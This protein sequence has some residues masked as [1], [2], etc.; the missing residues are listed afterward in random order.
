M[1]EQLLE[2]LTRLQSE[3]DDIPPVVPLDEYFKD[4]TVEDCI[5]CNQVGYGRPPLKDL[6]QHFRKIQ[7]KDEVQAVLVGLHFDW[8]DACDNTEDWPYA[9]N[10]HIYASV[11]KDI[12]TYWVDLEYIKADCIIEGWPYGGHPSAPKPDAGYNVYT[13]CWD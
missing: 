10:I 1:R 2:K 11:P 8:A 13:I 7:Q 3:N 4:N 6:Y 5:A 9:E 12:I